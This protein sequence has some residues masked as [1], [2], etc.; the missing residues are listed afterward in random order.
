MKDKALSMRYAKAF[1]ELAVME[2]AEL[3]V[4]SELQAVQ[5]SMAENVLFSNFLQNPTL[6]QEEKRGIFEKIGKQ[7]FHP[8]V[9]KFLILLAMKGRLSLLDSILE[10]FHE[11]LNESS[12]FEEITI[13]TATPLKSDV[14]KKIEQL[15]EKKLG[16]KIISKIKINPKLI[17]GMTVQ[18]RHQLFDG[19]IR[20]KLDGLK[21]Q[22][23]GMHS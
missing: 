13:T 15:L 1:F 5:K 11:L 4:E 6:R 23:V 9:L 20:T 21:Q 3:R 18:I 12:H 17:G 19:S 22:M 8:L 16:E 14:Q 10:S 7:N 2:K